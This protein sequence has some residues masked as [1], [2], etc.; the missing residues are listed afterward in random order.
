MVG[1]DEH[2]CINGINHFSRH[3]CSPHGVRLTCMLTQ[4]LRKASF[5]PMKPTQRKTFAG[6]SLV[7]LGMFLQTDWQDNKRSNRLHAAALPTLPMTT[8]PYQILRVLLIPQPLVLSNHNQQDR[9]KKAYIKVD[10]K[11]QGGS[12]GSPFSHVRDVPD[13]LP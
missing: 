11:M 8:I 2:Y 10:K 4:V 12:G 13:H 9:T 5:E 7:V 6:I 1:V 3:L